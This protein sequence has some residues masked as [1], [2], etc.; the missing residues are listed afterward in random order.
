MPELQ[1]P[2]Y[3][4]I[5]FISAA[6]LFSLVF[7]SFR[8][9]DKK[10]ML[11]FG[12]AMFFAGMWPFL[13]GMELLIAD[14]NILRAIA[15]FKATPIQIFP[16]FL[17]SFIFLLLKQQMP[18][19]WVLNI[20]WVFAGLYI[21]MMVTNDS[22]HFAWSH[23]VFITTKEGF[24]TLVLVPGTFI[25]YATI[26]YHYTID[27]T[28]FIMLS[29]AA[30]KHKYPYRS[31]FLLI[32]ISILIPV[33]STF[34]YSFQ[35]VSFGAYNPTPALAGLTGVMLFIAMFRYGLMSITP[36]AMESVFS[37]INSPVFILDA[38][39]NILDYN[40]S[41]IQIFRITQNIIGKKISDFFGLAGISLEN[42]NESEP[43]IVKVN[44]GTSGSTDFSVLKKAV[45]AG[46]IKGYLV[47]F[48][49]ITAQVKLLN[50]KHEKEIL[51]YKESILGDMHDGIGGVVATAAMAAQSA[52]AEKDTGEKDK[53]IT[54]I[55]NLL[56]NG[57]FEL[58]SML[59][60]LDKESIDWSS[61]ISDM[62]T[63]SSTVLDS[64]SINRKFDREGEIF[65]SEIS[66]EIYLSIF[67]LFKEIIINIVK[68]S[69]ASVVEIKTV[70]RDR[71]FILQVS[72]NGKGI[73]ESENKGFGLRNMHSRVKKLDGKLDILTEN[74]TY[75]NIEIPIL[76]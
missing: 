29:K 32:L 9:R 46:D 47:I 20:C 44:W 30:V 67:R 19:A 18:P 66:F 42:V 54:Q 27:I 34:L 63:F 8:Q 10:V 11:Y 21:T 33:V 59:N 23:D 13:Y 38:D 5:L 50:A 28:I 3:A 71:K 36:Y 74:G 12:L 73:T 55:A 64:R 57:S 48:T 62:R 49:D 60:I 6:I 72:D 2:P 61:L 14:E 37:T 16:I 26:F 40:S 75:I 65:E 41:A 56:E 68:H 45:Q 51:S 70:F 58:R 31:Q 4:L 22:H 52:L 15:P 69:E 35:I 24:N 76:H 1:F 17:L 39:E 7:Y 53:R 25:K 43:V